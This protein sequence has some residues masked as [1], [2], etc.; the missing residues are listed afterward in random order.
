LGEVIDT[1][2]VTVSKKPQAPNTA[3][4]NDRIITVKP[5][6]GY[7][8][9]AGSLLVKDANGN[10]F[11]PERVG[12]RDGGD[13]SQYE[14]PA[15]AK[16]PYTLPANDEL[17]YQPTA[18]AL[19]MNV[20]GVSTTENSNGGLRFVYRL[21]V[22][23]EN[24]KLYML[25]DGAK[26]EVKEYGLLL[27]AEAILKNPADLDIETAQDSMHVHQF[28]WPASNKYFDK[29]AEYVDI[30]VHVVNILNNNGANMNLIS[31]TYVRLVSGEVI[32]TDAFV[33]NYNKYAK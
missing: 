21:N 6:D 23:E 12:Y 32:Y 28:A 24:G 13:A 4:V 22:T 31:R 16:A 33:G 3:V 26:V 9:K 17:F 10:Y 30:S 15:E 8:L 25:S 20:V 14:I 2:A 5:A 18:D 27:A 1:C 19:N 11:V 7:E 29:C